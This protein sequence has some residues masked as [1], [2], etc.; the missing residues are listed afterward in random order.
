TVSSVVAP[1]PQLV[2]G[3]IT[4]DGNLSDWSAG[5][6]L[7]YLPGTAQPSYESYGKYAGNA[8]VFSIKA[9]AGSTI[10]QNTT[11]W[12]DSDRDSNTGYQIF[13]PSGASTG[14]GGVE[15]QINIDPDGKAYLYRAT[16]TSSLQR[17]SNTPLSSAFDSTKQTWEVAVS[18]DLLGS[19]PQAINVY[20]D[21]NNNTFLPGDYTLNSYTV[22]ANK[23]LPT[24]SD[25]SK[26]IGIVYSDTSASKYFNKTAYSQLFMSVQDE[27]IMAGIP[28]DLLTESDLKDLNK[29]VNYDTLVFPS[30]QNVKKTD[31]Q[32]IQDNLTD[33]VYRY[34]ISLVTAGNFMTNDETG[35]ALSDSYSRM[36]TLLNLQ[37]TA[38]GSSS[39]SL[40]ASNVPQPVLQG[41][42]ANETV[43][44]YSNN[45]GWNAYTTLDSSKP[46]TTLVNQ[47]VNNGATTYS[48]VVATQTGGRNIH[49]ATESYLGDTNLLWQAL[50]WNE[51]ITTQPTVKLGITRNN[52]RLPFAE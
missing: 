35:A 46:V 48:A 40:Q 25:T 15:F 16:G 3:N 50:Q 14:F 11:I 47:V 19:T 9:P 52:S 39:V 20:K 30:F 2:F 4:L 45:V 38:F 37:P 32:T 43:R 12:L 24:R 17:V 26:K 5:D 44:D 18:T 49:F 51:P 27:A 1:P 7:D 29:L 8:F 42:T 10:D 21:V 6:R 22:F 34:G 28:F 41:Y 33:A 36:K 13:Q 23:V 31:L